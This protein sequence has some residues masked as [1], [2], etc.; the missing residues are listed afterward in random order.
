MDP[1]GVT[2]VGEAVNTALEVIL[3]ENKDAVDEMV[4]LFIER[5]EQEANNKDIMI[6]K[7]RNGEWNAKMANIIE[8]QHMRG[9]EII[10]EI[11]ETTKGF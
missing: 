5:I 7:D 2:D 11:I 8:S 1:Y 3:D 6:T 10:C 9:R 4:T